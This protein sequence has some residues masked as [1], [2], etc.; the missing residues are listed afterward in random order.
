M[1]GRG[2][3]LP[4]VRAGG[5]LMAS[6]S[7][8]TFLALYGCGAPRLRELLNCP[9][10]KRR[11]VFG[12]DLAAAEERTMAML[13]GHNPEHFIIDEGER[14]MLIDVC[15][16][17]EPTEKEAEEGKM[18]TIVYG[19]KTLVATNIEKAKQM[20]LVALTKEQNTSYDV[21]RLTVYARN[22]V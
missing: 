20:A 21:N 11:T 16:V 10:P 6:L 19:P 18:E 13:R 22:F 12:V 4:A 9:L 14:T 5:F 15:V 3:D 8:E 2:V 17:Q 7:N 1:A